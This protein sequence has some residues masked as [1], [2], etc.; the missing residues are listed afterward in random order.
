MDTKN[1]EHVDAAIVAG[2]GIGGA[3]A[4]AAGA[5]IGSFVG[6]IGTLIGGLA[7]VVGGWWAGKSAIEASHRY[8]NDDDRYY[9]DNFESSST[10][11]ADRSFD[12]VRSA[13]QLGHMA[14]LNPD[15]RDRE[16][17]S[18]EP[19]L[20]KGWTN[21][22]RAK[23][24]EWSAVSSHVRDAYTRSRAAATGSTIARAIDQPRSSA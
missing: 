15:Y 4:G 19:E 2:E 23:N 17:E 10:R 18:V 13:Y 20:Q 21:D 1:R 16:W 8:T 14:G 7:G 5:A 9:R 11:L 3:A 12:E 22:L 24:G 6:P